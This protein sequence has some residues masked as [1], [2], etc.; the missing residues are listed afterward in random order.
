MR[1]VRFQDGGNTFSETPLS[2]KTCN[3]C[4]ACCKGHLIVEAYDLDVLRE[5]HLAVADI[6]ERT[7]EMS[8]QTLMAELEQH[9]KCLVIAAGQ[10]CKFL[11]GN[12]TCAIYPTRPNVCV[13]L[14]PGSDQC[15]E[16]REAEG[17]A[18]LE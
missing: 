15:Q 2:M 5:P 11:R 4:G 9:G 3:Q 6:S 10:E 14:E 17:L 7:R 16:A 13:A 8:Y 12:N 1:E 18:P